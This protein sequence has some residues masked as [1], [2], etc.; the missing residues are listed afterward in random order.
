MR[1]ISSRAHP[2]RRG[3]KAF[4][5]LVHEIGLPHMPVLAALG[6]WLNFGFGAEGR[7]YPRAAVTQRRVAAGEPFT[8]RMRFQ[9][10][11][12]KSPQ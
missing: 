6:E 8:D 9:A 4:R 10:V 5:R 2:G 12:M 1:W 11:H 7:I 3:F